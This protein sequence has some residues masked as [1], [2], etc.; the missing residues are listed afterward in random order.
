MATLQQE[1]ALL[2]ERTT[3]LEETAE[4]TNQNVAK[5]ESGLNDTNTAVK[6]LEDD[7]QGSFSILKVVM[8]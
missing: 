4:T 1:I 2:Q 6:N 7:A 5:L 3:A 8:E